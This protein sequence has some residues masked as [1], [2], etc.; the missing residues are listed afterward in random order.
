MDS[1]GW[2]GQGGTGT[3]RASR[4]GK[5]GRRREVRKGIWGEIAKLKGHLRGN[6]IEAFLNRFVYGGHLNEIS[7]S[8][9][10]KAPLGHLLSTNEAS[11]TAIGLH[12]IGC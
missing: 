2:M 5:G 9:G 1:Y 6:T 11:S 3:G 12:L 7:R 10:D 4:K 8:G